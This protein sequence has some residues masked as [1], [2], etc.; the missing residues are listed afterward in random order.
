[1]SREVWRYELPATSRPAT[2]PAG[3]GP[4]LAFASCGRYALGVR[5]PEL[6]EFWV[7]AEV[8]R[9]LLHRTFAV[10]AT[11]T[12]IPPGYQWRG[13]APRTP[14]GIVWHLY[15]LL[16]TVPGQSVEPRTDMKAQVLR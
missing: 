1:V 2:I 5:I 7:E 15:E 9:P 10:F 12:T 4:V 14:G 13:T 16:D 11:G 8:E 3:G 6:V